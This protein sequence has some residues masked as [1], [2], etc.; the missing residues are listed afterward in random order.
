MTSLPLLAHHRAGS[1]IAFGKRSVVSVE[2]FIASAHALAATLPAANTA[3]LL[4]EDRVNFALGF[5]ALLIRGTTALLPP[6]HAPRVVAGIASTQGAGY[7]LVDRMGVIDDVREIV[8]GPGGEGDPGMPQVEPHRIAVVA[9]T[10]GTTG[11]PQPHAKTWGSMVRGAA[12]LRERCGFAPGETIVG[13]VPP[14]HMWGLEA[15]VMLA[16]QGG[17]AVCAATPLLPLDIA[18]TLADVPAPRRLVLTPLHA[19]ACV[20]ANTRL[21][22]LEGT[23][24]ATAPLER[25]LA[26]AF[27]R[28]SNAPLVEIYGSTETGGMATRRTVSEAAFM[29][30]RGVQVAATEAGFAIS[31]GHVVTPIVLRDRAEVAADGS[32]VL[33]G[34]DADLVK[35]GGKRA[36]LAMLGATL[37]AIP[38]VV[39][40]EFVV[41]ERGGLSPRL[42][43]LVVAPSLDRAA[44]VAALRERIDPVFLPRP[45][46]LVEALP[47]NALGKI[48]RS[49]LAEQVVAHDDSGSAA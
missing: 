49:S 6:S 47:R 20:L 12:E 41:V 8:V 4:C 35:V 15:T 42:A 14:Q 7:A 13:A 30:F 25:D 9:Y 17:G 18:A 38:G 3:L 39:D 31:G 11:E 21:P 10:S 26:L 19:R 29:P 45:L 1:P 28:L 44:I 33:L 34:R 22:A 46:C 27:E 24:S 36:S 5:S 37:R 43:A 40:A 16:L 2:T 48:A 23:L 32:F